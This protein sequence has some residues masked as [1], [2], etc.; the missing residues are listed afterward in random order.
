CRRVSMPRVVNWRTVSSARPSRSVWDACFLTIERNSPFP[1]RPPTRFFCRGARDALLQ[2]R[3]ALGCRLARYHELF[4][5]SGPMNYQAILDQ[6]HAEIVP[7]LPQGRQAD[8]IPQLAEVDAHKF[9]MAVFDTRDACASVG[10]AGERFSIQS[11]S[12]VFM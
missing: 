8:Y 6:I 2:R 3:Y 1:P 7:T 11:I 4:H 9:G 10:D 12:K 5:R